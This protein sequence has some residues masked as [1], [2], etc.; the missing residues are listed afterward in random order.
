MRVSYSNAL[1]GR[2]HL[3]AVGGR[4]LI[5]DPGSKLGP[6]ACRFHHGDVDH[7]ILAARVRGEA[8]SAVLIPAHDLN[9][10]QCI[11]RFLCMSSK[12]NRTTWAI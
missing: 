2:T 8:E 12:N 10:D 5:V 4:G 1:P 9:S 6:D 11:T 3:A 7:R